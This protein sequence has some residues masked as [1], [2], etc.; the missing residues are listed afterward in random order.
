MK[1]CDS[2]RSPGPPDI[3]HKDAE[4]CYKRHIPACVPGTPRDLGNT[5]PS[6]THSDREATTTSDRRTTS[7]LNTRSGPFESHD[8]SLSLQELIL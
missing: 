3:E 1:V 5:R 8:L 6:P 2:W 7:L 4:R